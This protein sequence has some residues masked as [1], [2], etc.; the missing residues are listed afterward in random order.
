MA[1]GTMVAVT[2]SDGSPAAGIWIKPIDGW[3]FR[4][5]IDGELAPSFEV[6]I[7]D[8]GVDIGDGILGWRGT[9]VSLDHKYAGLHFKMDP[10]HTTWTGIVVIW[11]GN[12]HE[13]VFSGMAETKGLECDWL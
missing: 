12:G 9:V 8:A 13:Q 7:D 4:E 3:G 11:V 6:R 5:T 10:R 2:N 1:K